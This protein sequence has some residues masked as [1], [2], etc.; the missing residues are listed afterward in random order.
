MSSASGF[1]ILKRRQ[2]VSA[3]WVEKFRGIPVA[4][5]S[6]CMNR[7]TGF[8]PTMRPYHAEN[9]ICGPA[10]TVKTR[11]GDNLMPH[12]ALALAEP[13]DVMV[14]DAGG[15]LTNSIVGERMMYKAQVR[16][17]AGFVINGAIRD[18]DW[19]RKN[20]C[21]VFASGVHHRG[22]YKTGPGEINVPIAINDQFVQPGDLIIGDADGLLCIPFADIEWLYT[23]AK[24]KSDDET[25]TFLAQA[26]ADKAAER[27]HVF[28]ELRKAGCF[29]ED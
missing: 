19:V 23:A 1:R 2:V 28:A 8:G 18:L 13:G 4:C 27:V 7:L 22:P 9:T 11:P 24:K 21:P 10:I 6:D 26:Q 15:D 3:E 20:D 16:G 5:I 29:I 25:S 17:M 12:A 14:V